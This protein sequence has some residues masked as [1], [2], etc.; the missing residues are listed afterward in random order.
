MEQGEDDESGAGEAKV[1]GEGHEGRPNRASAYQG[2]TRSR[3]VTPTPQLRNEIAPRPTPKDPSNGAHRLTDPP[4]L[5][6]QREH[7]IPAFGLA[8]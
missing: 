4:P 6:L 7:R 1:K 2:L 3:P 8:T 5:I